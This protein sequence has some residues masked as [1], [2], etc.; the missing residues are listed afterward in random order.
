[1]N[2]ATKLLIAC[3]GFAL[4]STAVGV[5]YSKHQSRMTFIELQRL[6]AERDRLDIE[7]GQLKI[8]QSSSATPGRVE[9]VAFNELKMITPKPT[10]VRI[11]PAAVPGDSK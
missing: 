2:L 3:C 1:M 10:D 11:V 8:Q 9:Q 7:W 4:L 5:I 6:Q